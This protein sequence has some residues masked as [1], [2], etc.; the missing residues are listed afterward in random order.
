MGR[1]FILC[2]NL[3]NKGLAKLKSLTFNKI[4]NDV[5]NLHQQFKTM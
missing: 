4:I 5:H 1:E 2:E 3:T